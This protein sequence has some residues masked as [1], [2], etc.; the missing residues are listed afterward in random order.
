MFFL[1]TRSPQS[2]LSGSLALSARFSPDHLPALS[3]EQKKAL[4]LVSGSSLDE[5]T[6]LEATAGD[7]A[8]DVG[9][10]VVTTT[11]WRG[12]QK[13][14]KV[15]KAALAKPCKVSTKRVFFATLLISFL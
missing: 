8:A 1:V 6:C 9:R 3:E 14:L 2:D 4:E 11:A 5:D 15:T 10:V 13:D 7:A 12:L